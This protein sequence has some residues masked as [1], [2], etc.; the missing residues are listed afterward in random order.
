MYINVIVGCFCLKGFNLSSPTRGT[1]ACTIKSQIGNTSRLSLIIPRSGWVSLS[2][3]PS[4]S[5]VHQFQRHGPTYANIYQ[6]AHTCEQ[7]FCMI[8]PESKVRMPAQMHTGRSH[9]Y[10][11]RSGTFFFRQ[12]DQVVLKD[13]PLKFY[14]APDRWISIDDSKKG[15]LR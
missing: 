3:S 9:I 11:H 2:F 1:S 4:K 6:S 5:Q 8:I 14:T 7:P 10:F 12:H 13:T 15:T